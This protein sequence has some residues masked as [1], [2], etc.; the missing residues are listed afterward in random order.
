MA[1]P[2]GMALGVASLAGIFVSVVDCFEYVELGR[3][4]GPDFD[5]CQARLAA[6][7]LELTR[8]G[9]S[10]GVVAD[11]QTGRRRTVNVGKD[12][13][14]TGKQL[15]E[16]ICNDIGEVEERS[17][18]YSDRPTAN[19]VDLAVRKVD[20]MD[21]PIKVLYSR[22]KSI[23]A[24]R[25][26]EV[27]LTQK[28]K[29]ALYEK[30]RFDL[31][32]DDV[33]KCLGH[34]EKLFPQGVEYQQELCRIEVEE[35]QEGQDDSPEA[36]MELL[37]DASQANNDTLLEQAVRKAMIARGSGHR[38]ER[39]EVNDDVKLDQGDR[40]ASGFTGQA[41]VGRVGHNFGV[42]IGRGR[43]GIRQGDAFG[44]A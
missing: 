33:T 16:E 44:S 31:L 25:V 1:E 11:P 10:A 42:T 18:K 19:G 17:R 3:R 29:W 32:L 21:A 27:S 5:K 9:V 26:G 38:W 41:P 8:W 40:I 13:V 7:K 12:T 34:L 4:F 30:K 14:E 15:L 2:V 39:T 23:V 43:A 6:L 20:D 22:T 28:A 36:V 24:K 35:V 37:R